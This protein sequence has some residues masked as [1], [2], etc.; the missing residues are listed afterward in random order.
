MSKLSKKQRTMIEQFYDFNKTQGYVN[1]T[2]SNY[3]ASFNEYE[4]V[5]MDIQ[6]YYD[7]CKIREMEKRQY[8]SDYAKFK[9]GEP[10]KTKGG[11]SKF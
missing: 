5:G 11:L 4:G 2:E 1:M 9:R 3:I 6:R 7:D 8:N 10:I